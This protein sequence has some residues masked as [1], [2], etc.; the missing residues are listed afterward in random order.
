MRPGISTCS[1]GKG[2]GIRGG[3]NIYPTEVEEFL[4]THPGIA[5]VQVIGVRDDRY[6]EEGVAWVIPR[7]RAA[8]RRDGSRVLRRTPRRLR[9]PHGQGRT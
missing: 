5:D 1:A 4:Y 6:G 7:C 8:D 9:D 2:R 3:E